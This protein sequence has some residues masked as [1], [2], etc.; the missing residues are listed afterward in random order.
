[1]IRLQNSLLY[2]VLYFVYFVSLCVGVK[3][4]CG[5]VCVGVCV[6]MFCENFHF[7]EETDCGKIIS[8]AQHMVF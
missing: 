7:A 5:G 8:P 4:G 3:G 1:M 6:C 2:L